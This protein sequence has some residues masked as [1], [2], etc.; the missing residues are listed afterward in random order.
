MIHGNATL[1]RRAFN[2]RRS[3]MKLLTP[4]AWHCGRIVRLIAHDL[5]SCLYVQRYSATKPCC[6]LDRSSLQHYNSALKSLLRV[7][8]TLPA[9]HCSCIFCTWQ[10]QCRRPMLCMRRCGPRC[11]SRLRR[12]TG[13][14][15]LKTGTRARSPSP[16]RSGGTPSA[17]DSADPCIAARSVNRRDW[18]SRQRLPVFADDGH[19]PRPAECV[20]GQAV[21][22]LLRV[23][24]NRAGA[25]FPPGAEWS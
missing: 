23:R 16:P 20:D 1:A 2:I 6:L 14:R 13:Q 8:V 3:S 4:S 21:H 25:V 9:C 11:G 18:A 15:R 24:N 12:E 5:V 22:A 17:N 7:I 19:A 10:R